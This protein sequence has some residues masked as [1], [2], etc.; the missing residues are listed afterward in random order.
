M[1]SKINY[2]MVGLF[3]ISLLAGLVIFAYWLGKYGG[4][5]QFKYYHVHMTESVAG[6][7]TDA[8]VKYRGVNIGTVDHIQ[9]NPQNSEQVTLLLKV[10]YSTPVKK[11]T[12]ATLKSFGLTGLTYVEL[13]GGLH[14]SPLLKGNGVDIPDIPSRPSTLA[15]L[16]VSMSQ[17]STKSALALDKFNTL[18]SDDNLHNIS[19]T[20]AEMNLFVKE[21]RSQMSSFKHLVDNGIE[22]EQQVI[23]TFKKVASASDK[24][25][26]MATSLE[27]NSNDVT[28]N[29]SQDIQQSLET[30]NQLVFQ[31]DMLAGHLLKTSQTFEASPIDLLLKQ[32]QPKLGPGEKG[33]DK[34]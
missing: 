32:S 9:L 21:A 25:K 7:S 17:L 11:D 27:N 3:V 29:M 31:V 12:T 34:N 1:E 20:L 8:S 6:L 30:F 10:N 23:S 16:D 22:M 33:Y 5:E 28:R 24:M 14:S 13:S 15:R 19:L 26:S 4:N 18:L 2:T